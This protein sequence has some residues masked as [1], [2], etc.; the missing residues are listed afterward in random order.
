MSM[1]TYLNKDERQQMVFFASLI[2]YFDKVIIN[3]WCN[4]DSLITAEEKKYLRMINTLM[5]KVLRAF[6]NRLGKD[7]I[8]RLVKDIEDSDILVLSKTRAQIKKQEFL[9]QDEV[10]AA[11]LDDIY[12]LAGIAM[13]QCNECPECRYEECKLRKYLMDLNIP[14]VNE[15]AHNVCQYKPGEVKYKRVV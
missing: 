11:P 2:G 1:K 14:A 3:D 9:K 7:F 12:E 5:D 13:M 15:Y 10:V 8:E 4:R 6:M